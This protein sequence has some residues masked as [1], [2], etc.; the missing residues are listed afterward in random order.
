M[1]LIKCPECGKEVSDK[2]KACPNC[3]FEVALLQLQNKVF[4]KIG[5]KKETTLANIVIADSSR[6]KL[7]YVQIG[8]IAEFEL[9][10]PT[11]IDF[12]WEGYFK[13]N[14]KPM[15]T[16]TVEPGKKYQTTWGPAG[17][18]GVESIVK[19]SEVNT[20]TNEVSGKKNEE[21]V[22]YIGVSF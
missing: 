10:E 15:F 4:I 2:A 20:F 11:S 7:A 3:G 8:D 18:W 5:L 22:S 19:C 21:Y 13:N 9:T 17:F 12:Y 14:K 6:N 16:T 1:A